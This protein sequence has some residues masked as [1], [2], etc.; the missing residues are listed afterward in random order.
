MKDVDCRMRSR[1]G[2]RDGAE[3]GRAAIGLQS[4]CRV[5]TRSEGRWACDEVLLHTFLKF[6]KCCSWTFFAFVVEP[7][8]KFLIGIRYRF[9]H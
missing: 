6:G 9:T 3:A 7:W 8:T 5:L 2:A 4:A 1:F